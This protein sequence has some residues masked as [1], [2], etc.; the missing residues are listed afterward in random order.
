MASSTPLCFVYSPTNY[1]S[2]H[3]QPW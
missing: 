2:K 1:H 3:K